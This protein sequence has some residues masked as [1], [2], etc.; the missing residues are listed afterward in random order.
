V[1]DNRHM[2]R[3]YYGKGAWHLIQQIHY[4]K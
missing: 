1:W 4:V 2:S 3:Y